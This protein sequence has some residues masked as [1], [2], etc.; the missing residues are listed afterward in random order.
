M[1]TTRSINRQSITTLNDISPARRRADCTAILR[2]RPLQHCAISPRSLLS[3]AQWDA[4]RRL[5]S[6]APSRSD[7]GRGARAVPLALGDSGERQWDRLAIE[8]RDD[9]S[10]YLGIAASPFVVVDNRM[11]FFLRSD[12]LVRD[13]ANGL[14]VKLR[15]VV[16]SDFALLSVLTG[17]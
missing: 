1:S 5:R 10:R 9:E 6:L 3:P 17:C 4:A 8:S 15:S 12:R 13:A 7:A 2:Q 11:R 16:S 14:C